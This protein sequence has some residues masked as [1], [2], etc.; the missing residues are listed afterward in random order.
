MLKKEK[1]PKVR[2]SLFSINNYLVFFLMISFIV[3]CCFLLFLHSMELTKDEIEGSAK[4]TFLNVLL[5]S[6][7]CTVIDSFRRKNTIERPVKRILEATHRITRGD[8]TARIEPIH[9]DKH[10][11]EFDV[12]IS[13][14]N[15]MAEEISGIET[16]RTDFIANVSHEIKTP[17]SVIHNYATILQTPG[18][19]EEKRMEYAKTMSDASARL[20]DLITNILKLSKLENQQIFPE[21]QE[22]NLTEQICECLIGFEEVW[23]EKHIELDTEL[24]EDVIIK[25]DDQLL[26]L[27]WNNLLSNAM[28]FTDKGG[29]VKVALKDKDD[30][31][32]VTIA[33]SGC[34]MT[35]EAGKHIF[36]KFYQA[37]K[38][39]ATKGNG[40]GLALVKRVVDIIGGEISVESAL[41]KGS[42]FTVRIKK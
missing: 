42:R 34:G 14:F 19:P 7:I 38:S 5:L 9:T 33:D 25:L 35:P 30:Y 41:G 11:N 27:V 36:E 2:N 3:T 39:H 21:Y 15:K 4:I 24:D 22:F 23:E 8:F 16:F 26:T 17:I 29:M 40:L 18:L 20:A 6:L 37:D 28:K 31:V 1:K 32:E 10:Q 12:I 13:D